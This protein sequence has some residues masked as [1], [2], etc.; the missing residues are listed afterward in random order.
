MT[1]PRKADVPDELI[2]ALRSAPLIKEHQVEEHA[3]R[4]RIGFAGRWTYDFNDNPT[5]AELTVLA[6]LSHGLTVPMIADTL[7]I[8]IHTV[9]SEV[10]SARYR[11]KAKNTTHAVAIAVRRGLIH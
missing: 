1:D 11:L 10:R 2:R 3:R 8:S 4:H 7:E 6:F 9:K 5:F